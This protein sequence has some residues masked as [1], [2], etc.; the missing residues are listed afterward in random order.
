[1]SNGIPANPWTCIACPSARNR[2]ATPRCSSTSIVRAYRPPARE[3]STSWLA[4]RSTMATSTLAN[5]SS[6][7]SISPVGPPPAITT[8]CSAIR[9]SFPGAGPGS[10]QVASAWRVA[11]SVEGGIGHQDYH[12]CP[13]LH[14]EVYPV[15]SLYDL[16]RSHGD[17]GLEAE[18]LGRAP[19]Q[20]T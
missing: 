13:P 1:M 10:V 14:D 19:G 5:A 2:S 20:R 4:R 12:R 3:L 15:I 16:P 8:A 18:L 6:P 7:A 17:T 9:H 11:S